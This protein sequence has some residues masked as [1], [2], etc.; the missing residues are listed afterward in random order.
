[1]FIK[2]ICDDRECVVNTDYIIEVYNLDKPK[3]EAYT[4][5]MNYPYF[6]EKTEWEDF[7][8]AVNKGD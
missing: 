1:M 5:E 3:V 2:A 7:M 8:D 4:M 6:I